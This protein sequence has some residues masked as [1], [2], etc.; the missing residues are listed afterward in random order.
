MLCNLFT[1]TIKKDNKSFEL[2]KMNVL[3]ATV[4]KN[5]VQPHQKS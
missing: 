5:E 2:H 4:L 3:K 1:H